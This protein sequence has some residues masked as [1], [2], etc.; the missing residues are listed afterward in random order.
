[1]ATGCMFSTNLHNALQLNAQ[2][3]VTENLSLLHT[4][5][6]ICMNYD[7][8]QDFTVEWHGG[9]RRSRTLTEK[10]ERTTTTIVSPDSPQY[11]MS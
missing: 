2:Q 3:L 4:P 9:I 6:C 5:L 1:M 8:S 10:G 7:I 11:C